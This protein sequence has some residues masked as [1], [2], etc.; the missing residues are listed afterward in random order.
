MKKQMQM[1]E[2]G[3]LEQDGGTVDPASGNKVPMGSAKNEV[4][5]DIPARLS[6]GEFVFPADVVRYIGLEKLMVM[7]Q[8]AKEGLHKMDAMGQMGNSDEATIP[9]NV[10]FSEADLVMEDEDGNVV[11]MAKGGS[12]YNDFMGDAGIK[13]VRYVNTKTGDTTLVYIVNGQQ[14]PALSSEWVPEGQAAPDAIE[15]SLVTNTVEEKKPEKDSRDQ[16]SF[17]DGQPVSSGRSIKIRDAE[18]WA[19]LEGEGILGKAVDQSKAP[20]GWNTQN[21][22]EYNELVKRNLPV[23]AMW[24]GNSWDVY[25]SDSRFKGSPFGAPGYRGFKPKYKN[26]FGALT[27]LN[28]FKS[29]KDKG[30]GF[31]DSMAELHQSYIDGIDEVLGKTKYPKSQTNTMTVTDRGVVGRKGEDTRMG[32]SSAG[33]KRLAEDKTERRVNKKNVDD[34]LKEQ[35]VYNQKS[36]KEKE[37]Q[38]QA[39]IQ[40]DKERRQKEKD[41]QEARANAAK[42]KANVSKPSGGYRHDEKDFTGGYFSGMNKGGTVKKKHG[43]LASK[44]K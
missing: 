40:A 37:A 36:D 4:S 8:K 41:E 5:D 14:I 18:E 7:R 21:Q 11:E 28:P 24:N 29:L 27:S 15:E 43:G 6:E 9:D 2:D 39:S 20:A 44:K 23:E 16:V 25:T 1:F 42:S 35:K 30:Q 12:V 13:Q 34:I 19:N 33:R 10:P 22:R 3:G 38:R 17:F 26:T 32:I 31:K